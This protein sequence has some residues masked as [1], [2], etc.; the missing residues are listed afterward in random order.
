MRAGEMVGGRAL[1]A[2]TSWGLPALPVP[3]DAC[4]LGVPEAC[5]S[6]GISPVPPLPALPAAVVGAREPSVR[7]TAGV[8]PLPPVLV[9][10]RPGAGVKAP[11]KLRDEREGGTLP[12]ADLGV[13]VL[14]AAM[15][16]AG[17]PVAL[18]P[19]EMRAG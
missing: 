5:T 8:L 18:E 7:S 4:D 3:P 14:P 16:A 2:V 11:G 6:A 13:P 9:G 12:D 15:A 10:V 19:L 17:A 1:G